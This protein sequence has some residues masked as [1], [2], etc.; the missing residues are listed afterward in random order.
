MTIADRWL[1]PDGMDEVL[2]PQAS[3]MEELRR[4]L[5]DLYHRWGYDQVMPPPVEFLDSLLTGTGTDLDLQTF[6]LTDQLTG[7]MM[8]VSA[9]VTPQVARMDAHSMKRQGPVR[10]CYC[11]NVLRAKADQHQGGR[12]PVQ[13][14]VEL[15]GHAGLEADLEILH[16]A[17]ASLVAA[18][19]GEIHLALGHIGIY[20]SLVQAAGLATEQERALFE[21]LELKS[22]G[23]L[24]DRVAECVSDPALAGMFMALGR[25]HGGPEVLDEAREAFAEA[26]AAVGAAL[27]QLRALHRGVQVRHPEVEPYFDLAELRGYQYHT[28]MMF[29]AYVPGYGQALAK[30]GRYDD[31]GRAFGRARPA[32]GFSMDL[33]LLATLALGEPAHDG[34]WAPAEGE[35][36]HEAIAA[37]RERGERVVQALPDQRTGPGEHRCNRRLERIDGRWEPRSL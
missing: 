29:A 25:L 18:G 16:L 13:V 36:L 24:A 14:G 6:K 8:G 30:G 12:S 37:L 27:D 7:R 9:D 35:G 31:T 26:P 19:A 32:T 28:G 22:P 23:E 21:A 2:P 4:A 10:L 5:L 17:L 1:L 20:R 11:T 34:V 3:R 33:K 15:F